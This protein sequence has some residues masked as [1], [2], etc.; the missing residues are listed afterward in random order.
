MS[1]NR[2]R[3]NLDPI[4][5]SPHIPSHSSFRSKSPRPL[6]D[7]ISPH[8]PN[9]TAP[10]PKWLQ[11]GFNDRIT[12]PGGAPLLQ[13]QVDQLDA[14]RPIKSESKIDSI[15]NVFLLRAD[16]HECWVNYEF[17]V[18]P[19]VRLHHPLPSFPRESS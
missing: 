10:N 9:Q 4:T 6:Q 3:I 13:A 19:D 14:S 5:R 1:N 15:Q 11:E 7:D 12:D 8:H 17:G 2:S 18:N 16:L